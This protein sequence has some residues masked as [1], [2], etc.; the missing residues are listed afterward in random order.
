MTKRWLAAAAMALAAAP[1]A[2]AELSNYRMAQ[3]EEL[4]YYISNPAYGVGDRV[5]VHRGSIGCGN[6]S[7]L[8]SNMVLEYMP[9]GFYGQRRQAKDMIGQCGYV[10]ADLHN[11]T[12]I[13]IDGPNA[14]ALDDNGQSGWVAMHALQLESKSPNPN[15]VAEA[16]EAYGDWVS[17][18]AAVAFYKAMGI[19][20][21][22]WEEDIQ[23]R[24][25]MLSRPQFQ[26]LKA[27]RATRP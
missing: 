12:I 18:P 9:G 2:Y 25:A 5:K 13:R 14:L 27:Q 15:S 22:Q 17:T 4:S 19:M 16:V 24:N 10:P 1:Y 3:L 20:G 23:F 7:D 21:A 8:L 6:S 11:Q 26:V